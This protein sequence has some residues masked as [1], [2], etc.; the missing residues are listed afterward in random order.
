MTNSKITSIHYLNTTIPIWPSIDRSGNLPSQIK[1]QILIWHRQIPD[2]PRFQSSLRYKY[3]KAEYPFVLL[4]KR[5]TLHNRL[6][7]KHIKTLKIVSV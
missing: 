3:S 4:E 2:L 5:N 6:K 1:I 7:L